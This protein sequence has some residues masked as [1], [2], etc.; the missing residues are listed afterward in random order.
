MMQ[1][2]TKHEYPKPPIRTPLIAGLFILSLG[3]ACIAWGWYG[4][5]ADSAKMK[6]RQAIWNEMEAEN[7][8]ELDAFEMA[9]S[10]FRRELKSSTAS[11]SPTPLPTS[12]PFPHLHGL[13]P[14]D[15]RWEKLVE[16][17]GAT[18]PSMTL[19]QFVAIGIAF[20]SLGLILLRGCRRKGGNVTKGSANG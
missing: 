3:T 16:G 8:K 7:K 6:E 19:T 15:K 11:T 20:W 9:T 12:I 10:Q 13:T 18:A 5:V 1:N 4:Y 17:I 14:G 2:N